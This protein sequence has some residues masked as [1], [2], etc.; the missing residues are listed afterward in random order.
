MFFTQKE[1][2]VLKKFVAVFLVAL[3]SN[4]A[5]AAN[6]GVNTNLN[7]GYG[8]AVIT[9]EA[10]Y[11]DHTFTPTSGSY[12]DIVSD[13]L[14]ISYYA[15]NTTAISA[16][17]LTL[18]NNILDLAGG[19][20]FTQEG[21]APV[22]AAQ[23]DFRNTH[24]SSSVDLSAFA[25]TVKDNTLN[26]TY[27]STDLSGIKGNL[28]GALVETENTNIGNLT[29]S[30]NTVNSA[31][32]TQS[33]GTQIFGAEVILNASH[34]GANIVMNQDLTGNKVNISNGTLRNE[35]IGGE[36]LGVI[37]DTGESMNISGNVTNNI[38]TITKGTIQTPVI[39]GVLAVDS[40][41]KSQTISLTGNVTGNELVIQGGE[42]NTGAILV[43]GSIALEGY[44]AKTDS[45][46][47]SAVT[48]NKITISGG[49]F[50]N[51]LII[52]GVTTS[53]NKNGPNVSGAISG[54]IIEISGTATL[55]AKTWLSG[56]F[57]NGTN[58][59]NNNTLILKKSGLSVFGVDGFDTYQFD[60]T[61]AT[62]GTVYL[63][64][65]HGNG[66]DNVLYAQFTPSHLNG[67]WDIDGATVNWDTQDSK[68]PAN[69]GIG[70]TVT[71]LKDNSGFGLS[72]TLA[73]AGTTTDFVDG[74]NTYTYTLL[75]RPDRVDLVL[76]Q[77]VASGDWNEDISFAAGNYSGDDVTM[78]IG[79][80]L[81]AQNISVASNAAATGSL[82]ANTLDV[83]AN[84]TALNLS[85]VQAGQLNATF[86]TINI[87]NGYNLTKS[88][89]ALYTFTN[90]NVNSDANLSS[91][92]V[93]E[94]AATVTLASAATANI[95][96][97]NL[98]RGA[99]L[100]M[101]GAGN[102][103]FNTL[104]TYG[105]G[106]KFAAD[107]NA[108]G[109]NLNFFLEDTTTAGATAL[110]VTGNADI[111]NSTVQVGILGGPTAVLQ[112][113]D[114]VVLVDAGTLTGL[115]VDMTG[116]GNTGLMIKYQ[117]DLEAIGNQLVATVTNTQ[118][119]EN[120]KAFSEGRAVSTALVNQGADFA[121]QD[122]MLSAQQAAEMTNGLATFAAIGGGKSR[123]ETGSHVDLT[124][125]NAAV[126]L[127]RK[128]EYSADMD[129]L[130]SPF[131][132]YGIADYD[133]FNS[134]LSGDVKG[135]G[136]SQYIG[137]GLLGKGTSSNNTYVEL[138]ARVGRLETDFKGAVY[139]ANDADYKY[140]IPYYAAHL[141]LGYLWQW[142]EVAALD[143]S[144]K[145]FW[146]YQNAKT[147]S[148][149]SGDEIRFKN[150]NSSRVRA[151]A[152]LNLAWDKLWAPYVG[153]AYDYEFD[154]KARASTYG[155]DIDAPGL[156]GGTAL[157]E[158]GVTYSG[159]TLMLGIGAE[160]YA[161]RRR[162][163]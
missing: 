3:L 4:A 133:T 101:A 86:N 112:Q 105:T 22:A 17:D 102:Y 20:T 138:S 134:F 19:T 67:A 80:T 33:E 118:L 106:S 28:F 90:M 18:Q 39:G 119:S 84:N 158:A 6:Y 127:T 46:L 55:D 23:L 34:S 47:T 27:H 88:G 128:L 137:L 156:K 108:A 38:V 140:A 160:G 74:G 120:S 132:E 42:Y 63:T 31:I 97:I 1:Q 157:A 136:N 100:T 57:T 122:A 150:T 5:H 48:G 7:L 124:A 72:G 154:G 52:G 87:D 62:N 37:K 66:H 113:N 65:A 49:N 152:R 15:G 8:T 94:N 82:T 29:I 76:N 71:L 73:N 153:A 104:N 123:Y 12:N 79:G 93:A 11:S 89:N 155:M 109:K 85:A 77:L 60:V 50:Y 139:N 148:I 121:A 130:L 91:L 103:N 147:V 35:V 59:Y 135:K 56:G 162:G 115:P 75:Q 45:T 159:N 145:Y 92:D 144:G 98:A 99:T 143:F 129:W 32:D 111:T 26:V 70:S 142:S 64:S 25:P 146:S 83:T 81:K 53:D 43:G 125:F 126:G 21:F 61:N 41:N 68:R 96:E 110:Q 163:L 161:G 2:N 131:I 51:S 13:K 116:V 54:N 107:L 78:Q 69:L 14:T 9:N 24:P 36:I 16:S 141:G 10:K 151:G 40:K 95:N 114:Q 149:S 44:A 58:A 30:G 117:F